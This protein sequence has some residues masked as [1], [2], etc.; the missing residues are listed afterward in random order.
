VIAV[1]AGKRG[2]EQACTREIGEKKKGRK[3]SKRK[4]RN[5]KIGQLS[6]TENSEER[7]VKRI[8]LKLF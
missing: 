3:R 8:L 7:K 5:K 2:K 6:K 1:C 4:T